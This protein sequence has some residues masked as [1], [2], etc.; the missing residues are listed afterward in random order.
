MALHL[1]SRAWTEFRPS[2]L[3]QGADWGIEGEDVAEASASSAALP[4]WRRVL[5]PP[6]RRGRPVAKIHCAGRYFLAAIAIVSLIR[7]KSDPGWQ[8]QRDG[9]SA[10]RSMG[11]LRCHCGSSGSSPSPV[12]SHGCETFAADNMRTRWRSPDASRSSDAHVRRRQH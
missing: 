11:K 10:A 8:G 12:P 7:A 4:V 6:R 2:A 3:L 5:N 9:S 1:T